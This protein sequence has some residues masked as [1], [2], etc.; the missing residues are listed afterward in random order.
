MDLRSSREVPLRGGLQE[1]GAAST[2]SLCSCSKREDVAS[3][4]PEGSGES[5]GP[6]SELI[7]IHTPDLRFHSFPL[8]ALPVGPLLRL[9]AHS[10]AFAALQP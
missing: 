1:V 7:H 10:P 4:G 3:V 6:G 5:R 9:C 2:R 8:R